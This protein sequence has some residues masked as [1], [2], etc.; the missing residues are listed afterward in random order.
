MVEVRHKGLAL[1]VLALT[2]LMIVLD[3]SIVNVAL[4]AIQGALEFD[5]ADLQWIVTGYTLMFGGF[6]LLGGRIADRYGRR[7][8]FMAGL[9]FFVLASAIGGA[10]QSSGMLIAARCIQGLGGAFMSPAALSLLTVIFK[11]GPERNKALGIWGGIAAGGAAIGVLLGG[12]LVEYLDWRWIFFVNIPFGALA[13]FGA[14]AYLPES[15]DPDPKGFDVPGAIT[16]TGGLMALVYGLVRGNELGWTS[17]ETLGV[18][19]LSIAL[20]GIFVVLQMKGR[21]PLVP[22][23]IFSNRNVLGA[24]LSILFLGAGMFA[25]FFFL[26]LY[27]QTPGMLSDSGYSAIRTGLAFLPVSFIIGISAGM[28]SKLMGKIAPGKLAGAG[29]AIMTI[30][31]VLLARV[32]PDGTYLMNVLMPMFVLGMGMGVA[33]V[34]LTAAGVTGVDH[35]DSGLASALLNTGQQIGGALGLALLTAVY[36]NRLDELVP[37]PQLNSVGQPIYEASVQADAWSWAFLGG[38]VLLALA[39]AC[40]AGIIKASKEEA[41]AAAEEGAFVPG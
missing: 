33:F 20:L 22:L 7:R 35:A 9:A 23:R 31:M 26:S 17:P 36:T 24:D 11:E 10:A 12:V 38:A 41:A 30:G 4:R 37:S 27:I 34:S 28:G 8:V 3:A 15:V 1:T 39:A 19:A 40:A 29:L 13:I 2:Q 18:F 14:A 5:P 16:V 25:M 32:E 6:L 21:H